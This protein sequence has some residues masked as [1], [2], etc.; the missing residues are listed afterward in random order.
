[1]KGRF[2][3]RLMLLLVALLAV[4][5]A[6]LGEV[7][8]KQRLDRIVEVEAELAALAEDVKRYEVESVYEGGDPEIVA[9]NQEEIIRLRDELRGLKS[10]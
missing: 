10:D 8:K 3:L 6:A 7:R 4:V 5:F 2:G 1:M 9:E